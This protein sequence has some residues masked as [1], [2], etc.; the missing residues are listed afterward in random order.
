ML[1][2]RFSADFYQKKNEIW[3]IFISIPTDFHLLYICFPSAFRL[4]PI[5]FPSAFSGSALFLQP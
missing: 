4:H 2:S 5:C 1:F 3:Q